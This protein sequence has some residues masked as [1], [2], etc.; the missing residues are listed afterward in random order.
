[1]NPLQKIISRN[2]AKSKKNESSLGAKNYRDYQR[3][4]FGAVFSRAFENVDSVNL[5]KSTALNVEENSYK[6]SKAT[7]SSVFSRALKNGA[8]VDFSDVTSLRLTD[9]SSNKGGDPTRVIPRA[10]KVSNDTPAVRVDSTAINSIQ[11]NPQSKDLA[12]SFRPNPQKTYLYPLV[13]LETV[14]RFVVAPSKGVFFNKTIK[15]YSIN[16]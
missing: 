2:I 10:A 4:N 3:G 9:S 12:V 8:S 7:L 14:K 6:T 15:Q 13:P 16:S 1:M 11:Y 5:K